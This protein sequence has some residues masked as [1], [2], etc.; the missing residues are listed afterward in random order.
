M[1][2][3]ALGPLA[4]APARRFPTPGRAP[5]GEPAR[6]LAMAL[7]AAAGPV[8]A[9]GVD[10]VPAA[11]GSLLALSFDSPWLLAAALLLIAGAF[12]LQRWQRLLLEHRAHAVQEERARADGQLRAII[13]A[14]TQVSIIATDINGVITLFNRGA[15]RMLGYTAREMEGRHKPELLHLPEE[16][17]AR[18]RAL[19]EAS[20]Q[21]VVGLDVLVASSVYSG[22]GG[23]IWTYVRKDGSHLPVNLIVSAV[24]DGEG[25]LSGYLGIAIDVT[26]HLAAEEALRTSEQKLRTLFELSPFGIVLSDQ[27]SRIL[28]IN[29]AFQRMTGYSLEALNNMDLG[30][31]TPTRYRPLEEHHNALLI[32]TGHSGAFEEEIIRSDGSLVPVSVNRMLV[33]GNLDGD[34]HVWSMIEDI[35]GRWRAEVRAATARAQLEA[36]IE[37]APAAVAMFDTE[38][39]YINCSQRWLMDFGLQGRAVIGHRHYDLFPDVP[40]RWKMVHQR[41]LRGHIERCEEDLLRHPD[42]SQQWLHWEVRPW[43]DAR[44]RIG[45]IVM[46]V[47]DITARKRAAEN[48]EARDQ[49]LR[50]LSDRVPGL[51]YQY[52]LMPN[53]ERMFSYASEA[54]RSIYEVAPEAVKNDATPIFSRIHPQDFERVGESM[55]QSAREL[56]QWSIDYRVVLP[57]RGLRWLHGEAAPER[58]PDGTV[59]WH[60]YLTDITERKYA[61]DRLQALSN[62]LA[63]ATQAGGIGV[64]EWDLITDE[65][66]WDAQMYEIYQIAPEPP[67]HDSHLPTRLI[68]PDDME[69]VAAEFNEAVVGSKQYDVEYRIIW[70]DGQ[71]RTIKSSGL[72]TRDERGVATRITGVSWDLTESRKI[73][74]LKSEF[75]ATVSHELRTPL[76]SIRGTLGLIAGGVV[77]TLPPKA[78]ELIRIAHKN[79]ERLSLLINDILDME[80]IESGRMKFDLVRQPLLPLVQQAIEANSGYAHT[81]GVQLVL[82]QALPEVEAAVDAHR[83]LQVLANLLSNAAKFS[84]PQAQVDVAML[85]QRPGWVRIEVRDRGPGIALEFQ[86]R[87]FQKFSQADA[88]DTRVKGGTGLGLSISKALVE[89]MGGHIGFET[90]PGAGAVFFFELPVLA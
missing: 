24:C 47:E 72:V 48:L 43:R 27:N 73:E 64:W 81:Y 13:D 52:R 85:T 20:G 75:V 39:R 44:G 68:H 59:L 56:S 21:S 61:E 19:S 84:P 60:G 15:E 90:Q 58:Q 8:L 2:E 28:E 86:P 70:P 55:R 32:Q 34:C 76:T 54:I 51:L 45:G 41:C 89:G 62:R 23:E 11:S 63:L 87:I 31:V 35:S 30:R 83:I 82:T 46:F 33:A 69:R 1:I 10:P 67:L 16:V 9:D 6:R 42:G 17:E 77:G 7:C 25:R 5:A 74:R 66:V 40:E 49:L 50:K 80:K 57:E 3:P 79:S 26:E 12:A 65:L 29:P 71:E 78:E 53:G 14:A 22:A 38:L 37:Y 4:T 36:F 18:A 88:S